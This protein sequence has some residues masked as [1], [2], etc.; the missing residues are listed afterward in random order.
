MEFS[1][2]RIDRGGRIGFESIDFRQGMGLR[3]FEIEF[4]GFFKVG[5]RGFFRCA[6]TYDVYFQALGGI[7]IPITV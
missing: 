7:T 3:R 2:L 1:I 4:D 5:E 6:L